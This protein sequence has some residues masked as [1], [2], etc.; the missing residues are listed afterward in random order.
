MSTN[1]KNFNDIKNRIEEKEDKIEA[2]QEKINQYDNQID[3][4]MTELRL[5]CPHSRITKIARSINNR[6]SK[7]RYK[8]SECGIPIENISGY[9]KSQIDI[10]KYFI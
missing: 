10:S 3:V 8:C 4:L 9:K 5:V 1:K 2:Y 6:K 7:Q